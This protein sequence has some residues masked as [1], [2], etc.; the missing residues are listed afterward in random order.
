MS[1][2]SRSRTDS[3]R[4]GLAVLAAAATL[5]V[6]GLVTAPATHAVEVPVVDTDRL[7]GTVLTTR[8]TAGGSVTYG[9]VS[10]NK[11]TRPPSFTYRADVDWTGGALRSLTGRVTLQHGDN[12]PTFYFPLEVDAQGDGQHRVRLHHATK[13]GRYRVGIELTAEIERSGGRMSSHRVNVNEAKT[14]TIRRQTIVTSKISPARAI[15]GR[16]SRLSGRVEVLAIA[17]DRDLSMK[18]VTGGNVT[19]AYDPDGPYADRARDV[20]VRKVPISA[21]GTF[22][23]VVPAQERW[24]KI[25]YGGNTR[26]AGNYSYRPQGDL[27]CGC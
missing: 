9:N 16:P 26:Y 14:V 3:L 11:L 24:W 6:G 12:G 10:T 15:D 2:H 13:P 5:L 7:P 21:D 23:T 4:R 18:P 8:M 17:A 20:V 1:L 22:S 25:I 19:I 27:G